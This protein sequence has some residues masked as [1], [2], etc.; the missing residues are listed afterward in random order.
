LKSV[1]LIAVIATA[2]FLISANSYCQFLVDNFDYTAGDLLTNN[3]WSSHSGTG[4]QAVTVNSGGLSFPGY[5]LS[6]IGN[7]ALL[8]NNGEDI[9]R[10]FTQ[11][12]SGAVYAAFMVNVQ[13]VSAGYFLHFAGNPVGST[14]RGKVFVDATNH[15]GVSVGNNTGTYATSTFTANST[16]LLVLKYEI[17]AGTSNDLV[18]LY[19][20]NSTPP[21]TE[22]SI[23]AV[24]P[25][26]D[27]TLPDLNPASIALRQYSSTQ[28]YLI[29]GIRIA[30]TWAD[31]I[32]VQVAAPTLQSHHIIFSNV[33]GSSITAAWTRGN[34]EKRICIVNNNPSI[35]AP[36][37]GTDPGSNST[38]QGSGQQVIYNGTDSLVS[39]SG[40]N[41]STTYWFQVFD[42][43]GTG[44]NTR[45]CPA[46]GINN[47]MSQSTQFV[48]APPVLS[49]P[50]ASG[51]S[52]QTAVLGATIT[53][54]GG[55]PVIE[56]G[57]VW[58]INSPVT[59]SDNKLAEGGVSTGTFSHLRTGLP[60]GTEVF[61]AAYAQN[62]I[63]TTLSAESGFITL[64]EE[65]TNQASLFKSPLV[66]HSTAT[67]SWEDNNGIQPA[68][69]FLIKGNTTGTFTAPVD[70]FPETDDLN[71]ADG[72]TVV[73]I[74]S[75][76]NT[77]TWTSLSPS[78]TYYFA[79]YPYSNAGA[80]IDY[81]TS[82]T[83]PFAT[84][85]TT[86]V[87]VNTYTWTGADNADWTQAANWSPVRTTPEAADILLFNDGSTK[88]IA[89]VPTQTVSRI[90]V[91][92]NTKI[93][94][95]ATTPAILTIAGG[96]GTDLDIAAGSELNLA[97]ANSIT[98]SV[99]STANAAINGNMTFTGGAHRLTGG[100][101][102]SV[103][104]N[105]GSSFKAGTG[106]A[107]N[108]FGTA[109]PFNA[110]IFDNGSTYICQAGSNP[111]GATAPNSVVVFQ[112]GSLFKVIAGITAAFSGRTYGNFQLD[113]PGATLT[114][115]GT[116]AVSIQNL[117][118]I[119]GTL[120]FNMTG[121]AGHSIKGSITVSP[122]ATLSFSPTSAGTVQLNGTT[123]QVISGGGTIAANSFHTLSLSNAAGV[124]LASDITIN[125]LLVLN[126]CVMNLGTGNLTLG[127]AAQISGS[128]SAGNMITV[129]GSGMLKKE[130]PLTGGSFLYPVG[131]N[132]STIEYSPVV[133]NMTSGTFTA[134]N[135]VG[136]NLVNTAHPSV[137]P[138]GSNLLR[139]WNLTSGGISSFICDAVFSYNSPS[140]V[141]GLESDISCMNMTPIPLVVGTIN[142]SA[143]QLTANGLTALGSFTG[144]QPAKS[145][146]V[147]VLLEGLYSGSGHMGK[148]QNSAGDQFPGSIADQVVIELH[149][150]V[151]GDFET[152]LYSSGNINLGTNGELSLSVPSS[153]NS[154]YYLVVK[155]RNSIETVS[156]LPVSF[157]GNLVSYDFTDNSAKA[158]GNNLKPSGDGYYLVYCGDV[159]QDGLLDGDDMIQ[160][161]NDSAHLLL[162]YNDSDLNGDG[163]VNE[164]DIDLLTSN[165]S[166]FISV[167]KP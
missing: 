3:G 78:T 35:I 104:F 5:N 130:F 98:L 94:L 136:V 95:Q 91:S 66:S 113:A 133:L 119:S 127:S 82:L 159:N 48:I 20:F 18:S 52:T 49:P 23:P 1:K 140:D 138:G 17:V 163:Q 109:A 67:V 36:T 59:I 40:L 145:L 45:Y 124:N 129:S 85:T 158:K 128:F 161:D 44:I 64:A 139:Y 152:I 115:T 13:T 34:G 72:T 86:A 63:G 75:G 53:S 54:D 39:V 29:D 108:A 131:D 102:G 14:Y 134:G 77:Y 144:A 43:N 146:G 106:F 150:A 60:A 112:P 93:T 37:D 84:V 62:A 101:A 157:S 81:K 147:K 19:V 121:T 92:A 100:A 46:T 165:S 143:H 21:S 30:G 125:G 69:G 61:F 50:S 89:S 148:A 164:V 135:Y 8:D 97:G 65:P 166:N 11:Q 47:P 12:T 142:T 87:P 99:V 137:P 96:S 132:M 160:V 162:G 103:Y 156:A 56:R 90:M 83:T 151:T 126:G 7:A 155:H 42:Y 105:S 22:P 68:T 107:G 27:A 4:T 117:D 88:T 24:G 6:S 55:S 76:T 141:S 38:Y 71:L 41:S 79:I 120:N 149:S 33:T 153:L 9:N 25:L 118:I 58:S 31:A 114:Q 51:I 116:G 110:I 80:I 32:G 26:S 167:K 15:F 123:T 154:N 57:T 122:G 74:A 73:N 2:F 70:G 111:F 28:N 16:Y 10:T